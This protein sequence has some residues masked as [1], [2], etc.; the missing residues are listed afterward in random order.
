M[1]ARG[2]SI[3][4]RILE[5]ASKADYGTL[6]N[7][8]ECHGASQETLNEA[9]ARASIAGAHKAVN[10]VLD[11]GANVNA[12]REDEVVQIV[13]LEN[14]AVLAPLLFA[15]LFLDNLYPKNYSGKSKLLQ[16]LSTQVKL[17]KFSEQECGP[18]PEIKHL[19]D[20][21]RGPKSRIFVSIR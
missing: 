21:R 3:E 6:K 13:D 4:V 19:P 9:L 18:S 20:H 2:K 7:L 8:V 12:L 11:Q 14:P 10:F 5:S 1:S 16:R 15:G 17:W